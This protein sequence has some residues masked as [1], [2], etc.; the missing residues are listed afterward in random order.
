[1]DNGR[2]ISRYKKTCTHELGHA[3]GWRG[4]SSVGSDIMYGSGS[5]VTSLTARDKNHL[6][7]IYDLMG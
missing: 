4:H 2:T 7:Q 3:L 6:R 5:T 1:M